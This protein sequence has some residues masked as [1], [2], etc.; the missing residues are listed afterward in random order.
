MS[1]A[2]NILLF[3]K[4]VDSASLSKASL[5]TGLSI[6]HLSKKLKSLENDLGTLL[7]K[8]TTRRSCLT[9]A[10]E[11]LYNKSKIIEQ[12]IQNTYN[13][14]SNLHNEVCGSIKIVSHVSIGIRLLSL[15]IPEFIKK[16]PK[17]II[18]IHLDDNEVDLIEKEFDIAIRGYILQ[19]NQNLPDSGYL[20]QKILTLPVTYCASKDYIKIHGTPETPSD[21]VNHK[22]LTYNPYSSF[23]LNSMHHKWLFKINNLINSVTIQPSFSS[24]NPEV[25]LKMV[26]QGN[27]IAPLP[28]LA[29]HNELKNHELI[30]V[31]QEYNS[32]RSETYIFY[33]DRKLT[34][35]KIKIFIAEF[36]KYCELLNL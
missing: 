21:L 22:C 3:K 10:G 32:E 15:F 28:Y 29:I 4:I 12:E 5:S 25:L 17:I 30:K 11:L 2:E 27:G 1:Q 36:K 18:D 19:D 23:A 16:Y 31:L 33:D 9:P 8:R 13:E 7:I 35:K 26:Q 34:Q 24:N 14:I 6:S 20:A